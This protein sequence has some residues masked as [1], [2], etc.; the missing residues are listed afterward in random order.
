[1]NYKISNLLLQQQKNFLLNLINYKCLTYYKKTQL[2]DLFLKRLYSLN[3]TFI[4]S[5]NLR[6]Y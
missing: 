1:M 5:S 4:K 6:E 2:M 3:S